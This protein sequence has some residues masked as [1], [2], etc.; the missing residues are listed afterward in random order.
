MGSSE[1]AAIR[2][3]AEMLIYEG[4]YLS[5][6]RAAD[7]AVRDAVAAKGFQS[8]TGQTVTSYACG[9]YVAGKLTDVVFAADNLKSPVHAKVRN[10]HI[11]FLA[12]PYEG[13]PRAVRGTVDVDG[14]SGYETSMNILKEYNVNG[15]S[16]LVLTTG[17]EYSAYL[18]N[19][20]RLNVLSGSV[21]KM[22]GF[23][24]NNLQPIK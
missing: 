13:A 2:K 3:K 15:K 11:V 19:V 24:L 23:L 8:F 18:E 5:M 7:A 16:G 4:I 10:G 17:T 1:V 22:P 14:L 21:R 9:V 20:R 12:A 6:Q